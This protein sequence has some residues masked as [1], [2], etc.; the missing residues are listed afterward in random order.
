MAHASRALTKNIRVR[1]SYDGGQKFVPPVRS[2]QVSSPFSSGVWPG[3]SIGRPCA[4]ISFAQVVVTNGLAT[5]M[6]P[7]VRSSV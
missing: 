6:R 4:S 3:T 1:G 2:G 7:L 5:M